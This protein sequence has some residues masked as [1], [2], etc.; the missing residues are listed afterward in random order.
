MAFS[1]YNFRDFQRRVFLPEN[2]KHRKNSFEFPLLRI[3]VY[4]SVDIQKK[5]D[6]I[7]NKALNMRDNLKEEIDRK[8]GDQGFIKVT[9]NP[10]KTL[11]SEQKAILNRKANVMFNE[12]EIESA[13]RIYI[14]TGYSDGL[15]RVGNIY[16][17]KNESLKAL[18]QYVL[19]HNRSKAE[20]IY[21]Q[22]AAIISQ[23]IK[24]N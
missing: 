4:K 9:D 1:V 19:A 6:I 12:G 8:Q 11:N 22:I 17:E 5:Y 13:R 23:L 3:C 16:E 24:E 21:E 15:T 18:K 20:P 7:K 10:V 14:T 2:K